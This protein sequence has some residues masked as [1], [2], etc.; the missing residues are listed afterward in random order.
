MGKKNHIRIDMLN[1]QGFNSKNISQKMS[2]KYKVQTIRI[3]PH[4]GL[5]GNSL[6]RG[7]SLQGTSAHHRA[8][9]RLGKREQSSLLHNASNLLKWERVWQTPAHL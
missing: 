8:P 5:K 6:I 2:N 1:R 9:I 3:R 7:L 4:C